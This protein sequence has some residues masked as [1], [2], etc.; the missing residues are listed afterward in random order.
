MVVVR[1]GERSAVKVNNAVVSRC[2]RVVKSS[3]VGSRVESVRVGRA[4]DDRVAV[5]G[6]VPAAGVDEF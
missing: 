4:V 3:A 6:P 5:L 1:G 2:D